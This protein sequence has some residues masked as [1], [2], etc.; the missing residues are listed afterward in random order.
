[1]VGIW[2]WIKSISNVVVKIRS[3]CCKVE[4]V[5]DNNYL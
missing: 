3:D 2:K 1:M 5:R 4:F